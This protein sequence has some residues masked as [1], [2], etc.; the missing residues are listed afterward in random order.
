METIMGGGQEDMT[1]T[2]LDKQLRPGN[3]TGDIQVHH[4]SF[5][6]QQCTPVGWEPVLVLMQDVT[7]LGGMSTKFNN[8]SKRQ[9]VLRPLL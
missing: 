7:Y 4:R 1:M 8:G 2:T 6:L 9:S 5:R 3:L